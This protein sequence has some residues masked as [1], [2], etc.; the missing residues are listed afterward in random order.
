MT[1]HRF[2]RRIGIARPAAEVFAWHEQPGAF[3]RLQP[4]WEQVEVIARSGGVRDGATV[5]LRTRVGP[6]WIRWDVVH[7][8]YLAGRQFRD[9]LRR[10][11]FKRWEH[12]HRVEPQ[13]PDACTLVDD[14]T[15]E[16]P[17]GALGRLA[18]P[19]VRGRLAQMFAY[20]HAV[21]KADLEGAARGGAPRRALRVL[22]SGASGLVGR[23]L[24]PLLTTQ[25][26]TVV[27][28][29]RRAPAGPDEAG[30]DPLKGTVD[31]TG[32][33]RIDALVN[34]AGAGIA[35]GRWSVP[36]RREIL[37]SRVSGTR[38]LVRALA[39]LPEPPAVMINASAVGFYGDRGDEILT[40]AS[41]GGR[42]FLAEV[43]SAW[44]SELA[45]A[46][47][48]GV[49]TVALR[50]G[51][52]VTPAGGGLARLLPLAALGLGGPLGSG[53]QWLGWITPDDLSGLILAAMGD[54]RW[55]GPVNAVAPEVLRQRE[56]A[57]MLG[58]VLR[59]PAVLPAPAWA[60]RLAVGEMANELLLGSARVE[61]ARALALGF[62]FRH[63]S[64]LPALTHM[65]GRTIST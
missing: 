51:L 45:A 15:Y 23:T 41:A 56:F 9:V 2:T 65:L 31:L 42:G 12:L 40:E 54:P 53:Q 11:P 26:H 30:W 34:L 59:R 18:E 24:V 52:V 29:V 32:V 3:E 37:E 49:R 62:A 60:L 13:G 61:P 7:G 5:S 47:A 20:R 48:L 44:E 21:T 39:R 33:G 25:G 16:L 36:R 17:G 46:T 19:M 43:C 50:T 35:D 55:S 4:P 38:T 28:L 14:I 8:D 22:V 10:G 27:K 63:G 58:K 57:R 64:L 6:A 1:T